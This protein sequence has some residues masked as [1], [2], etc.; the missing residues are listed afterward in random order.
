MK[1]LLLLFLIVFLYFLF[2]SFIG[3]YTSIR[4]PKIISTLTPSDLQL[5]YEDVSFVTRDGMTQKRWHAAESAHKKQSFSFTATRRTRAI[6]FLLLHFS[7]KLTICSYLIFDIWV[8]AAARILQLGLA[9]KKISLLPFNFS[10][11][12]ALRGSEYGDFLWG[13]P[14]LS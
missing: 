5:E 9:K 14:W 3:F 8:R 12:E 7:A 10:N 6:S 11:C 13:V 4:P 1:T 2:T